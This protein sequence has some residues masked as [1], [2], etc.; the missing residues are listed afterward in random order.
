MSNRLVVS[1]RVEFS[2][3]SV[4]RFSTPARTFSIATTSS[5]SHFTTQLVGTTHEQI[6]VGDATDTCYVTVENLHPTAV[7]E[8][9]YDTTG[10]FTPIGSM[11]PSDPPVR[12]GRAS[13]LAAIYLKSSI[14]AT[15]VSVT[16]VKIAV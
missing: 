2:A 13:S 6:S 9:G 11:S 14:A 12:L 3:D 8:Y 5:I 7:V 15:P 4:A 16:L 1:D 10:T